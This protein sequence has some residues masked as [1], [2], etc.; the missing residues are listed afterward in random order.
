VSKKNLIDPAAPVI[1]SE[2]NF[3]EVDSIIVD[4]VAVYVS[5]QRVGAYQW[6]IFRLNK[7]TLA[8]EAVYDLTSEQNAA[9]SMTQDTEFIYAGLYTFP[10]TVI[11]L[12]KVALAEVLKVVLNRGENDV[13]WIEFDH[14]FIYANTNTRPGIIVKIDIT[15]MERISALKL[16]NGENYPLSGVVLANTDFLLIG[17][18]DK[19]GK[20]VKV[21]KVRMLRLDVSPLYGGQ[22]VTSMMADSAHVFVGTNSPSGEVVQLDLKTLEQV[23]SQHFGTGDVM[24]LSAT[25]N[26]LLVGTESSLLQLSGF[27]GPVDCEYGDWDDYSQ[28]SER[29]GVGTKVRARAVLTAGAN[30]GVRCSNF[31]L[32]DASSCHGKEECEGPESDSCVG[33]MEWNECGRAHERSCTRRTKTP[34]DTVCVPKCECPVDKP[35]LG[36]H[37]FCIEES[38]CKADAVLCK[39]FTCS[40]EKDHLRIIDHAK[41]SNPNFHCVHQ[42][43]RLGDNCRCMCFAAKTKINEAK[44]V[45]AAGGTPTLAHTA[46]PAMMQVKIDISTETVVSFTARKMHYFKIGVAT[47]LGVF[48]DQVEISVNSNTEMVMRRR[49]YS[50]TEKGGD[51]AGGIRLE[52]TVHAAEYSQIVAAETKCRDSQFL[53]DLSAEV[54]AVA[55]EQSEELQ[56]DTMS[57]NVEQVQVVVHPCVSGDHACQGDGTMCVETGIESHTCICGKAYHCTSG[58][59]YPFDGLV[60]ELTAAPSLSKTQSMPGVHAG[61]SEP[62]QSM[63]VSSSLL[64]PSQ[65]VGITVGVARSSS[66]L[67]G[68]ANNHEPDGGDEGTF[69][70]PTAAL[71]DAPTDAPSAAPT[72]LDTVT[73]VPHTNSSPVP[74]GQLMYVCG[75]GFDEANGKYQSRGSWNG[76]PDYYNAHG[77]NLWKYTVP[78]DGKSYWVITKRCQ[79]PS[80]ADFSIP[81]SISNEPLKTLSLQLYSSSKVQVGVHAQE[82]GNAGPSTSLSWTAVVASGLTAPSPFLSQTA[83]TASPAGITDVTAEVTTQAPPAPTKLPTPVPPA[84]SPTQASTSVCSLPVYVSGAGVAQV[85][86]AYTGTEMFNGAC[87]MYNQHGYNMWR[88][89]STTS[90]HKWWLIT[91]HDAVGNLKWFYESEFVTVRNWANHRPVIDMQHTWAPLSSGS[92]SKLVVS[93]SPCPEYYVCGSG[94]ERANGRYTA[95]GVFNDALDLT[96]N[97]GVSLWKYSRHVGGH[98]WWVIS[99]F[100]E[101]SS[102][103]IR[104]YA[105]GYVSSDSHH[106][107]AD[108]T[109]E[110]MQLSAGVISTPIISTADCDTLATV[111]QETSAA[112]RGA[113]FQKSASWQIESAS[114]SAQK[115]F[116]RE[117]SSRAAAAR[118]TVSEDSGPAKKQAA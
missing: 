18:F 91:N 73:C 35:L 80:S 102:T 86:G 29:C 57:M 26:S 112:L 98:S 111:G 40:F 37:G 2:L 36:P 27:H 99:E 105:S 114:K 74:G 60:C 33:G 117:E 69:E 54:A 89:S 6:G 58:C 96:N 113:T 95:V 55:A 3:S 39:H 61:H 10:G 64:V 22:K 110:W 24:S 106:P 72:N 87:D 45:V 107:P 90:T 38:V 16:N 97:N 77:M 52:V 109:T 11:K 31:E 68:L 103:M 34:T 49:Y 30:G 65:H 8:Q 20:I 51:V 100:D 19:P 116:E 67:G 44:D 23:D 81:S 1:D 9:F 42:P 53:T 62:P 25:P 104:Y 5:A 108:I 50:N 41:T 92:G 78:S 75:A 84:D 21:D 63:S 56:I 4:D 14:P 79:Q 93:S 43:G 13:R 47:T 12:D 71:T 82:A 15:T 17:C 46:A 48:L 32:D 83:C 101:D 94:V 88:Y 85:N 7:D 118:I 70:S 76:S 59:E 66:G 115:L 28:C